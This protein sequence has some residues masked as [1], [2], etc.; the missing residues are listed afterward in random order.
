MAKKKACKI[1][2]ALVESSDQ[3]PTKNPNCSESNL[4]TLYQGKIFVLDPKQ[5]H[6]AQRLEINQ[7]GEYALKIR[8]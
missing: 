3:C 7:K 5:S 1:C 6:A 8:G 4:T 2:K